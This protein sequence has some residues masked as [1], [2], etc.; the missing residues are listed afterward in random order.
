MTDTIDRYVQKKKCYYNILNGFWS[1]A[2]THESRKVAED[3][4]YSK[5]IKNFL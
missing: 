1:D 5:G 4:I 2:G 3:Y